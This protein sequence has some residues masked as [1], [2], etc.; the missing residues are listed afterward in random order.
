M[1]GDRA[2]PTMLG[3]C[4]AILV[5]AALYLARPILAPVA[6]ALLIIALVWPL[7]NALQ[8]RLPQLLA[9]AITL[10]VAVVA[11]IALASMVVWGFGRVGQWLIGNA[12]RFQFSLNTCS[13]CHLSE[14]G[15]AFTMVSPDGPLN[16]PAQLARF[17]TGTATTAP[18]T[19][20]SDPE[21]GTPSRHFNDLRRRGQQLDQLAA[22][23]CLRLPELPVLQEVSLSKLPN[24]SVFA[25]GF[26]H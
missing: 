11:V 12:A 14:T 8:R 3:I 22:K 20:I 2:T 17:L 1:T 13:G 6:F 19:P 25:P 9:L 15:T 26:V 21:Y 10:F 4:T 24:G 7:Q 5:V 16:A 18:F 23:S